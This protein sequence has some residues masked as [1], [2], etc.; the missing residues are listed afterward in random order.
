[1]VKFPGRGGSGGGG[2]KRLLRGST[3]VFITL[4]LAL[5]AAGLSLLWVT[6]PGDNVPVGYHDVINGITRHMQHQQ[7]QRPQSAEAI[8]SSNLRQGQPLSARSQPK[9]PH[10]IIF[11][12]KH[13]ILERKEP[14]IFYNN[15]I[16]TR[17]V[18]LSAWNDP[19]ARTVFLD[20]DGC[21]EYISQAEPELVGYFDREE[22]GMFKADICRVAVLYMIGGYYFDIDLGALEAVKLEP[23]CTFATVEEAVKA[24][25]CQQGCPK[26]PEMLAVIQEQLWKAHEGNFFQAFL[27]SA[28]GHPILRGALKYMLLHYQGKKSAQGML[29]VNTLGTAYKETKPSERGIVRILQEF[30]N[31]EGKGGYYPEY[32][33]KGEG[34]CCQHIV[35]DS[36]ERKVYFHSR[37]VGSGSKCSA[38]MGATSKGNAD[39]SFAKGRLAKHHR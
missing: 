2:R 30:K 14:E 18:Y 31:V 24:L 7:Q 27:A 3:V 12:F 4:T 36:E 20:N 13:N 19:N 11:T 28:P 34:C 23:N 29:G 21:R 22:T 39:A 32:Q 38:P 1:M 37:I 25:N 6:S 26:D 16:N 17:D 9:I 33:Q 10:N 35:H 5:T 8:T 15:I